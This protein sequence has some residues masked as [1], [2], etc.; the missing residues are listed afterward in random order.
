MVLGQTSIVEK[1]ECLCVIG[2]SI[3]NKLLDYTEGLLGPLLRTD[4]RS[5]FHYL[6]INP[7]ASM[8]HLAAQP[9]I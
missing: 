7:S 3:S 6:R 5:G 1:V 8:K 9:L 2:N 4:T